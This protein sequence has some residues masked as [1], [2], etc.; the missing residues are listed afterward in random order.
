MQTITV[1]NIPPDLY[2]KLKQIAKENRRSINS[3]IIMC[4]ERAICS[5]RVETTSFLKRIEQ[6][7]KG[8]DLPSIAESGLE[9]ARDEGRS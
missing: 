7:Q 8:L 9:K 5:Q 4:I 2:K 6:L 3:E 1:K